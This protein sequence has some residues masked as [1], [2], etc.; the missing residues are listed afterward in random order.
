MQLG[1]A[2]YT[3]TL[4]PKNLQLNFLEFYLGWLLLGG[5]FFDDD[6]MG[7]HLAIFFLVFFFDN[8]VATLETGFV[9]FIAALLG[10]CFNL[11]VFAV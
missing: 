7:V 4:R 5:L 9:L 8:H 6:G 2:G 11:G 1:R 10:W 3:Q